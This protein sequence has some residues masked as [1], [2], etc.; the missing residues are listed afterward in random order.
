VRRSREER[1]AING[2][3]GGT[4]EREGGGGDLK[5]ESKW[6]RKASYGKRK[7]GGRRGERW[8]IFWMATLAVAR[9][10]GQRYRYFLV[11]SAGRQPSATSKWGPQASYTYT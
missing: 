3:G 9:V 2:D 7:G 4:K 10:A 6:K 8:Q 11:S 1:G 5:E